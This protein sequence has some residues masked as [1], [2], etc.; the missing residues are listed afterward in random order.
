MMDD[1][2]VFHINLGDQLRLLVAQPWFRSGATWAALGL[3]VGV[4][5]K[6]LVP[7][8]EE[9]GWFRTLGLGIAGSIVGTGVVGPW[10][11]W[12]S[13]ESVSPAG[14]TLGVGVAMVFVLINRLV[15]RS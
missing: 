8:R 1:I 10:L 15:T 6:L 11:G 3:G 5:A 13:P 9:M 7:G 14:F 12:G 2:Q 4:A